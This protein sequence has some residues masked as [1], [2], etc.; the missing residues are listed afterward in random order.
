M[1]VSSAGEREVT[2]TW[3]GGASQTAYVPYAVIL[4]LVRL[5]RIAVG[6]GCL[7]SGRMCELDA[8][9]YGAQLAARRDTMMRLPEALES[10]GRTGGAHEHGVIVL[11]IDF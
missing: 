2:Q 8:I 1:T 4:R 3:G 9:D 6:T 11:A 7:Q 5:C 10:E